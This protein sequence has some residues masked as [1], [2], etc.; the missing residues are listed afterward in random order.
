[1][2]PVRVVQDIVRPKAAAGTKNGIGF[3]GALRKAASFKI[4][5][6]I[7]FAVTIVEAVAMVK[8]APE[9]LSYQWISRISLAFVNSAPAPNVSQQTAV[10]RNIVV[11]LPTSGPLSVAASG[12]ILNALPAIQPGLLPMVQS[13]KFRASSTVPSVIAKTVIQPAPPKTAPTPTVITAESLLA[14]TTLSAHEQYDGPYKVTFVTDAGTYGKISWDLTQTVLTVGESVPTFS[15]SYLCDPQPLPPVTDA[16]DQNPIFNMQTSYTCTVTFT[17]TAGKDERPESRQ[18]SFM[19]GAGQLVV[20]APPAMDTLLHGNSNSG[21]FVFRNDNIAPVT[22]T[23]LDVDVSYAGLNVSDGPLVLRFEDPVSGASLYE[24]HMENMAA[25]PSLPFAHAAT[26]IHIPVSFT[27]AASA[28][29][30]FPVEVLGVQRLSVIGVDP[31]V[32]VAVRHVDTA[33][34]SAKIVVNSANISWSCIV[35]VGAYDP[36]ATTGPYATGRV[37]SQ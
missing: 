5:F 29:E 32:S 34:T 23:G 2:K 13:L 36:N 33:Q 10:V 11:Q 18:F 22:V 30:M 6:I 19:T 35:P 8:M 7:W 25:D 14:A 27:V 9:A 31:T 26:N 28:Q 3:F 4:P 24:Y 20:T 16:V 21:G 15:L 12:T 1:M 37:C 17:P